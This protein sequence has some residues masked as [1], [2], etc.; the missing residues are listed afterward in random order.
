[1]LDE[2]LV[3]DIYLFMMI[4]AR[5]GSALILLPGFGEVNVPVRVR[6]IIALA[7]SFVVFPVVSVALP[8][9]PENLAE[10]IFLL[11]GEILIGIAIGAIT[12]LLLSMLQV[13]GTIIAF[14]AGL[15]SAQLFDPSAGQTG[16]IT[17]AFLATIGITLLFVTNMHH[18][19]LMAMVDSYVLF[20]P[21]QG[22]PVGDFSESA[23][24]IV[25]DSF[26]LGLQIALPVLVVGM[27][28][29][30]AMG[31]MARLMPQIQVFFIAL[32]LQILVGFSVLA[33]TIGVSMLVFIDHFET[34]V[35]G[36][37]RTS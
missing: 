22:F 21:G 1:M 9:L 25:S 17:G 26:R 33:I 32:P 31:L 15:A 35:G 19:M 4:F 10:L 30:V 14:N 3:S 29:Y 2:L 6:L 37:L 28:I 24:R 7:F 23:T 11:V 12:R 34:V 8:T 27:L 36:F 13:G 18:V 20:I 5:L 16:A